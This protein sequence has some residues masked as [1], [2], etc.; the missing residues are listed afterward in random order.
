MSAYLAQDSSILDT[1]DWQVM[2]CLQL[3]PRASFR[4]I[5]EV[6][7]VSEQ[8]VARRYRRMRA[9]GLIRV[10]GLLNLPR[11][12]QPAW[13]VRIQCRPDAASDIAEALARRDDTAWVHI[14]AGGSEVMTTIR[15]RTTAQR[16]H[17][18]LRQL[19]R[20]TKIL[21]FTTFATLHVFQGACADGW[22]MD[23]ALLTA[24][25]RRAMLHSR[26]E[27]CEPPLPP[28]PDDEP[29]IEALSHDG[30]L[31]YAQLAT[32]TGQHESRV[33]RRMTALQAAGTIYF[34]IDA[35]W[36]AL[37]FGMTA[38]LWLRVAPTHIHAVG[39]AIA[40]S[41][42]AV[43]VAAVTGPYSMIASVTARNSEELYRYVSETIGAMQGI[44]QVEVAPIVQYVKQA[45]SLRE[46]GRLAVPTQ[47][48]TKMPQR[49]A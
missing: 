48:T 32:I 3:S 35:P 16:E 12:G 25:Q 33:A 6:L 20:T 45:G 38:Y 13:G 47:L 15:A 37:G 46:G 2:Q 30:R 5:A 23:D 29:L 31:T 26:Q 21:Q 24:Q 8:T 19:P 28:E 34:D 14:V 18:L 1:A 22:R 40:Q 49:S 42:P 10:V 17:L 39:E 41:G 43:F 7:G 11:L 9:D 36:D 44:E 4:Q 27:V